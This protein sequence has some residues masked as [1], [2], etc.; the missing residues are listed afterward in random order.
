MVVTKNQ[1]RGA[2]G[3]TRGPVGQVSFSSSAATSAIVACVEWINSTLQGNTLMSQ[4][5]LV[6]V[7]A[8]DLGRACSNGLLLC[9][10][11]NVVTPGTLDSRALTTTGLDSQSN[12]ADNIELAVNS[13]R[14]VGCQMGS[15]S[16]DA[17]AAG[18]NDAAQTAVYSML[19]VALR[20]RLQVQYVADDPSGAAKEC[21]LCS[22]E[23]DDGYA[24]KDGRVAC[25]SC[26]GDTATLIRLFAGG[27]DAP[28]AGSVA[29]SAP[30]PSAA[31]S[32]SAAAASVKAYQASAL[33]N[34]DVQAIHTRL[35]TIEHQLATFSDAQIAAG[36]H[37]SSMMAEMKSI[38]AAIQAVL[39]R[40]AA[41]RFSLL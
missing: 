40:A 25:V 5:G 10:L 35:S 21:S 23:I 38:M 41:V 3:A 11:V 14:S 37:G 4:F 22:V 34:P 32:S 31:P 1:T 24:V 26:L 36:A 8:S 28:G 2:G 30:R 19:K 13:A 20:N 33:S 27:A 9:Q 7:S 39:P 18:S 6:P 17:V 12:R 29:S 16:V 15:V